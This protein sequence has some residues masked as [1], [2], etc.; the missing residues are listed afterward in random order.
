MPDA[1]RSN[2][3][4]AKAGDWLEVHG[5]PGQHLR[6]GRIVEIMGEPGHAH[7]RVRWD[8]YHESIFYPSEGTSVIAG[9]SL[10][11]TG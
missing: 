9:E 11:E 6:R 7:Y 1:S 10:A 8:E 4:P 3:S 2:P 5:L